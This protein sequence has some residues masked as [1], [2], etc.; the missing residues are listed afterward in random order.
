MLIQ[1]TTINL[2]RRKYTYNKPKFRATSHDS[3]SKLSDRTV[4]DQIRNGSIKLSE[5]DRDGNTLLHKLIQENKCILV[6]NL[7]LD[8][9]NQ[10]L[11]SVKNRKGQTPVDLVKT[12]EMRNYL[13]NYI[14]NPVKNTTSSNNN[15]EDARIILTKQTINNN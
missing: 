10:K 7:L 13:S 2:N 3:L 4:F 6:Q 12:E 14:T 8:K 5:T 15:R 1:P 11:L 9:S